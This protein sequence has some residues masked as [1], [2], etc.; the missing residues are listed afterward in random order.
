MHKDIFL[1]CMGRDDLDRPAFYP[2]SS[3]SFLFAEMLS[4]V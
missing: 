3:E 2:V 1:A 4:T